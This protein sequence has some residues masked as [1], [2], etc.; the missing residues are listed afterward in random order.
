[1]NREAIN[2]EDMYNAV[3]YGFRTQSEARAN[4]WCTSRGTTMA[5]A[6]ARAISQPSASKRSESEP[7]CLP[8]GLEPADVVQLRTHVAGCSRQID[9]AVFSDPLPPGLSGAIEP[10]SIKAD[11]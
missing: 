10:I 11:R 7:G 1:M 3:E 5:N 2:P 8:S 9:A 6:S 4:A